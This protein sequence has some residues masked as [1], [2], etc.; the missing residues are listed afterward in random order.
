MNEDPA[1]PLDHKHFPY[2]SF[3]VIKQSL[4]TAPGL[5]LSECTEPFCL[6]VIEPGGCI[7]TILAQRPSHVQLLSC[8]NNLILLSPVC[9]LPLSLNAYRSSESSKTFTT[10]AVLLS[11]PA[12]SHALIT[13]LSSSV[14]SFSLTVRRTRKNPMV[15]NAFYPASSLIHSVF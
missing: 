12:G 2:S 7:V 14:C 10:H 8:P 13:S 9:W 5:Y 11:Q 1:D 4:K 15:T 3:Q 6:C